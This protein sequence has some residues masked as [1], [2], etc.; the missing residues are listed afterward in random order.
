MKCLLVALV[1]LMVSDGLISNFLVG[2]GLGREGNPFLQPLVGEVNF[3]V[4]KLL[5]GLLCGLILWNIYQR[6][7]KLALI[8]SSFFVVLCTGVVA[9][10]LYAFS[11]AIG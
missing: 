1:L 7:P 5:G 4:L 9:W 2:Y 11:I 3:L 8:S 10:N 6:R